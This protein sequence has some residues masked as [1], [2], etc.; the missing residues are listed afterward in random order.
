MKLL[1][2]EQHIVEW[3]TAPPL[4][5]EPVPTSLPVTAQDYER[6]LLVYVWRRIRTD[7]LEPLKRYV[8]AEIEER[9]P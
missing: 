5:Y 7:P 8:L 4:F 9:R 2:G 3:P 6:P 1:L